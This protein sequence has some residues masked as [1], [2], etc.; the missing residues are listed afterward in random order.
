MKLDEEFN[1]TL[2]NT[3]IKEL[4]NKNYDDD[5]I[6]KYINKL[7]DF[8]N[9]EETI[10]EKL[11]EVIFK[12]IDNNKNNETN[13][14]DIIDKFYN[15][16]YINEYTVDIASCF[17]EYIKDNTFNA[18]ARKVILKLEDNNILT[19]SVE[20]TKKDFKEIDKSFVEEIIKKYLDEITS[21]KV[22]T[23][24]EPKFLFNNN[25]PGLYNFYQDISNYINKNITTNYFVNEKKLREAINQI[26]R[27]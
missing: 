3:L 23:I 27:K 10:K 12:L 21:E 8:L 26:L 14:R 9:E 7:L 4:Y 15:N 24:L 1:K 16:N 18:Y 6:K 5:N 22:D 11:I 17:I 2:I 20:L 19:T 13:C 25:V